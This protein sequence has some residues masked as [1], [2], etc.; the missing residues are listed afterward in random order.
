MAAGDA[1]DRADEGETRTKIAG[2][3]ETSDEEEKNG[4]DTREK[5]S[6]PRIESHQ[7]G[8]QHG[9]SKHRDHVLYPHRNELHEREPVFGIIDTVQGLRRIFL[10]NLHG[11]VPLC[12]ASRKAISLRA[13]PRCKLTAMQHQKLSSVL[14]VS[15]G[16]SPQ[17]TSKLV[18]T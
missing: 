10:C 2:D 13:R 6:Y 7:N 15:F 14:R 4:S 9:A 11:Y 5:K 18:D 3:P 12:C 1:Q 16:V 8:R 17:A